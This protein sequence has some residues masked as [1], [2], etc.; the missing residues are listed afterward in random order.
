MAPDSGTSKELTKR[1]SDSQLMPPPK[2]IRRPQTV[3]SEDTY[4]SSISEIIRRD[5]FPGI[6]E[7]EAQRNLLDAVNSKDKSRIAEADRMLT[8]IMTPGPD[9]K[10]GGRRVASKTPT[11]GQGLIGYTPSVVGSEEGS[12]AG[13]DKRPEVNLG[14]SLDDFT[15]KYTSED[16]ESFN[17]ILGT[18]PHL[19]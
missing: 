15:A 18:T 2:R 12:D 13:G 19:A 8:E 1:S 11:Y 5:Y 6:D 9:G 16:N 17:Q 7:L 4:T 10:A 3:L 14:M